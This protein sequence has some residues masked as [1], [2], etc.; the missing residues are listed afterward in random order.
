LGKALHARIQNGIP[1]GSIAK[2]T[3]AAAFDASITDV[4]EP[5]FVK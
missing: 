3:T 2:A 1:D 4:R 5:S